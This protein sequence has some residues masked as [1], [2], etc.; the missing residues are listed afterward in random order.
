MNYAASLAVVVV[1]TFF[2]PLAVRVGSAFDVPRSLVLTALGACLTFLA[3][4]LF[5]RWQVGRHRQTASQLEQIRAQVN[6]D[7][8]NPR[9]YFAGDEH[10]V[11]LLL[12]LGRRREAAET[13]DRYARL[14]GARESEI[15]TLRQALLE[16]ER[17]QKRGS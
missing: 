13:I 16:A 10:M 7:P 5:I 11:A 17:R 8:R 2:F 14:G 3:T 15:M 9:A 4:T 1:L 12:R 6:A